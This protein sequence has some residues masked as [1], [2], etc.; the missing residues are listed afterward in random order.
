MFKPTNTAIG[1]LC[2]FVVTGASAERVWPDN[3]FECQVVTNSGARGLVS[4]QTT[5]R[6][7]A[8]LRVVGMNAISDKGA[9]ET[10]ASVVQCIDVK[11]G[12]TFYDAAF[13]NWRNNLVE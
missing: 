1:L 8:M 5:T 12:E 3:T 9:M 4:L 13:Q 2:L 11:R 10:A 7:N 6:Q